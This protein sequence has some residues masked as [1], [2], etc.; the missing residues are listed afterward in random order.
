M[1]CPVGSDLRRIVETRTYDSG[2]VHALGQDVY[3]SL[4]ASSADLDAANFNA[5]HPTDL[6]RLFDEYDRRFFDAAITGTLAE[7]ALRFRVSKRMTSAGGRTVRFVPRGRPEQ[8]RYEI[9][10]STTLL[11]Q[12][13]NG[14]DHRPIM[15]SGIRCRDRLEALQRVMEH[16]LVHVVEGLL[17]AHSNCAADRFKS[18]ASRFFD[19]RRST[20]EL[21]T[22][23]E[24]AL[25][26]FGIE[27]GVRV[28][29]VLDGVLR[30]GL[31]NRVTR[32]ATVLV[33]DRRGVLFTNGKRYATYYVPVERLEVVGTG[34]G[35][36]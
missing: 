27:P 16:E 3:R 1:T 25:A 21:I 11:F 9:S 6:S 8:A 28:R 29:F 13:F 19:H 33:T 31:V 10:V 20:H 12:C 24:R 15:V 26:R 35:Q 5:L 2:A 30:V 22:P 36:K 18:I 32:R 17:W 7:G 14:D 23:R 4:L 34:Q